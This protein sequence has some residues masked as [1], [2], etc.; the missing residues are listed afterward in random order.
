MNFT[1]VNKIVSLIGKRN[2]GKS[3]M[4]RYLVMQQ[5]SL[6]KSIFVLCPTES[7]NSFYKDLIK[8]ENIFDGYNE[9]WVEA[10]I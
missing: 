10:L 5:R 6:F 3:Q 8:K 7:V 9:N 1:L 4:L 2:S